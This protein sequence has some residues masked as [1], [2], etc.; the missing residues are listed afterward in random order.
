MSNSSLIRGPSITIQEAATSLPAPINATDETF[1]GSTEALLRAP[2]GG[3]KQVELLVTSSTPTSLTDVRVA[4]FIDG[5]IFEP[6][7]PGAAGGGKVIFATLPVTE[8]PT[9]I[10][11][12]WF[13]NISRAGLIATV[14][15]GAEITV[16]IRAL[17]PGNAS[18]L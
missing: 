7:Q 9:A 18:L 15:G 12:D 17:L 1:G 16:K 6:A 5:E 13:G 3:P 10:F 8:I 11:I 2:G 4:F 14:A